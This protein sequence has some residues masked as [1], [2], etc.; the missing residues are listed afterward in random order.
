MTRFFCLLLLVACTGKANG[1]VAIISGVVTDIQSR[2]VAL[3]SVH[4]LNTR[5]TTSTNASGAFTIGNLQL[6]KYIIELSAIGYAAI[7]KEIVVSNAGRQS[8]NFQLQQAQVQLEDVVVTAGK[9]EELMQHIAGSITALSA[10]HVKDYRLWNIKDLSGIVPN[11]YAGSPGDE[12][13]VTA[14]RG[15]TTSSYDPAVTTYIDGVNQFSLDTYIPQLTDIERIEIL[16]GP[17][18]TLYG[19]NA[20]GGVISIISK[21]PSNVPGGFA[22]ASFGNYNQQRY[23]VGLRIPVIKNK[24]FAG[25]SGTVSKRNGFYENEFNQTS[26]DRQQQDGFGY[27][28]K[29]LPGSKWTIALNGKYQLN[30]NKGAF[31]IVNGADEALNNPFVLNQNALG[32]MTDQTNNT[33][34]SVSHSGNAADFTVQTAW[35][36]NYRY[37]DTPIDGDFSPLDAVTV[38]NNY[39]R[40]WNNV[41]VFTTELRVNSPANKAAALSWTA[42]AY[43]FSQAVPNKQATHFGKDAGVI[44]VPGTDFSTINTSTGKNSGIAFYA[45]ANYALTQ[46]LTLTAGLRY[47]YERKK[48]QVRGEYQPDGMDAMLTL[49]DTSATVHYHAVSPKLGLQYAFSANNNLY[50]TY[51]RGFRT[52]GLTQL[53]GDPS[54]PPLYP[55]S[56]EYSNN[57]ELGSRNNFFD[58][59]LRVNAAVFL[60]YVNNAQV[61]TLVLPDAITITKNTGKLESKGAE[62]EI[63]ANLLKGLQV[64]YSIGYTDATYKSLGISSNGQEVN[65]TGKKQIFTPD[66]TS[67][68][69]LQYS[70]TISE[71]NKIRIV[72][73]GE[74]FYFGKRYFDF[75]NTIEQSGYNLLN[76]RAGITTKWLDVFCWMRNL[77]NKKYIEYGYDFGGIHLGNP[78]TIGITVSAMF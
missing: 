59:R 64:D 4:L 26:F 78:K 70:Y 7:A 29:Y 62:A 73:R 54:Q 20:M 19:R 45:Q 1:Q 40:D 67:M 16:R 47:D 72:G 74:W 36:N 63:S 35:Q 48:L 38:G 68:L 76:V 66:L 50:I 60:T 28:L 5:V 69:A 42:G 31:P 44:G 2:P 33:S 17:Q 34:L 77:A 46:K 75:A 71:K 41:K 56:P 14:V 30:K 13:N 12:R 39:G 58:N 61:P 43:F 53:S 51:S 52:G 37:Y 57:I 8:F 6:G 11:L 15:I 18:G 10:R 49:P 23:S 27:Y 24:L 22:E 25:G 55:Y 3:V 21:A 9:K 65:L 32:K